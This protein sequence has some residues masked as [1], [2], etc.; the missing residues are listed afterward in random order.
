MICLVCK[1]EVLKDQDKF[2]VGLDI[3]YVN[4][5]FHRECYRQIENDINNF[6]L[7]NIEMVYNYNRGGNNVE[8][9]NK[10]ERKPRKIRR[11]ESNKS[12]VNR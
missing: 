3:P 11:K 10:N 9:S 1:K 6:V 2:M 4:L 8:R 5:W 12:L 7:Q